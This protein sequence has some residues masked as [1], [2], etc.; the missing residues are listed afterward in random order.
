MRLVVSIAPSSYSWLVSDGKAQI[1]TL[2]MK[3]EALSCVWH[4]FEVI[5]MD[6]IG[7]KW[8]QQLTQCNYFH[9]TSWI[10]KI[11][12]PKEGL[13][14]PP[15]SLQS[16]FMQCSFGPLVLFGSLLA[17]LSRL[18]PD[19]FDIVHLQQSLCTPH[20][21]PFKMQKHKIYK[22][23][24]QLLC[25]SDNVTFKIQKFSG[26]QKKDTV[27]RRGYV[28]NGF[29]RRTLFRRGT[30]LERFRCQQLTPTDILLCW[31]FLLGR[32]LES[33]VTFDVLFWNET[34]QKWGHEGE[35]SLSQIL[36]F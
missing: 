24:Q 13:Q 2:I 30:T 36:K 1:N 7:P 12:W 34:E 10:Q 33:R 19:W 29:E 4:W 28:P 23:I 27:E 22:K 25:T 32:H 14:K 20:I 15:V 9:T 35:C 26:L 21:V 3:R 6:T 31:E 18:H 8:T 11:S 16:T 5:S 17:S